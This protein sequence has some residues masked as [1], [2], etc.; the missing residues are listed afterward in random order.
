MLNI[1]ATLQLLG[2][3]GQSHASAAKAG[4]DALTRALAAEWGPDG[5]RVNGLAPGP[6]EGT[7]GVRRLTTPA[8]RAAHPRAMPARPAR[9]DRGGGQR[10]PVPLF[11]RLGVRHRRHPGHRR[12]PVAPL[13]AR[14][15]LGLTCS[16]RC[17]ST[18]RDH[19]PQRIQARAGVRAPSPRPPLRGARQS[20]RNRPGDHPAMGV[21]ARSGSLRRQ[22]AVMDREADGALP[23]PRRRAARG[24]AA[25]RSRAS[26]VPARSASCRRGFWSSR[27]STARRVARQRPQ[28][29]LAVGICSPNG[30]ICLNWRLI[31]MPASV[32]DYV[33]IHELMHLKRMDHS[34]KFWKLVAAAC[35]AY[36]E[37]RAAIPA[38]AAPLAGLRGSQA[39]CRFTRLSHVVSGFQP[40]ARVASLK[41]A[42]A[43]GR[44]F[45][46]TLTKP[47]APGLYVVS[48]FRRTVVKSG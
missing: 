48:A 38:A 32:R 11:R 19:A 46:A 5:I 14:D 21:E 47:R 4:V 31:Q 28:S 7:E 15:R 13:R 9:D 8:S 34:P 43:V 27:P 22:P 41:N 40:T 36:R 26:S 12:R 25:E 20:R 33:M 2:T 10:G 44:T 18:A 39:I 23:S 17:R 6:V 3:V 16:L 45:R 1:S 24:T 35:P 30:H 42:P 29:A 37:A